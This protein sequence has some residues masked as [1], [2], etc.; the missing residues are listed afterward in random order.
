M[1][2]E[3]SL[4][5]LGLHKIPK[6]PYVYRRHIKAYRRFSLYGKSVKYLIPVEDS[7]RDLCLWDKGVPKKTSVNG[8]PLEDFLSI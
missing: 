5:A 6:K 4:M 1:C 2:V 3:N 8:I 7:L